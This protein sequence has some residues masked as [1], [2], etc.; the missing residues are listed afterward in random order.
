MKNLWSSWRHQYITGQ[1]A[2]KEEG[3]FMCNS[4][5][6][7]KLEDFSVFKTD[8][9]IINM[10]KFPYNNGH[11]LIS[12]IRHTDTLSS[13]EDEEYSDLFSLIRISE[14]AITELYRPQGMNIGLNQGSAAGAGVPGHL[15]FHILPRWES[16]TNFMSTVADI[17]VVS[18][19]MDIGKEN[20]REWFRKNA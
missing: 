19:A 13:L 10:N 12:P 7:Q 9:S 16:D 15:H 18:E 17:K 1:S 2:E 11:L 3:C 20:L 4:A 5:K 8:L 6:S 14:K